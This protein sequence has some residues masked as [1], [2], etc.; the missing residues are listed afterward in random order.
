MDL[1]LL[2][3]P[4]ATLTDHSEEHFFSSPEDFPNFEMVLRMR[5]CVTF[6]FGNPWELRQSIF[7][8]M[9]GE[10]GHW[11]FNTSKKCNF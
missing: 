1:I 2:Y 7:L 3:D 5:S 11:S 6:K 9:V 4:L 10:R 8:R